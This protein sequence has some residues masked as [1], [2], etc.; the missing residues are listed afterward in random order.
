[1]Q[2][3]AAANKR[4]EKDVMKL[5]MSGK[6]EVNLLN[7]DNTSEFEVMFNGP[8]DSPYEGVSFSNFLIEFLMI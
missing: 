6:F 8:I 1:M 2:N 7:E 3:Q 4:K 5:M